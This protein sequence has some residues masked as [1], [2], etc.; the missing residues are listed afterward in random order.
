MN[1]TVTQRSQVLDILSLKFRF[2]Q[3][4]PVTTQI[5]DTATVCR[6]SALQFDKA[7]MSENSLW[8][9]MQGE[10]VKL[11]NTLIRGHEENPNM[12]LEMCK[13]LLDTY[14]GK[15]E[16]ATKTKVREDELR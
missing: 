1:L 5:A 2:F 14:E 10:K 15:A 6:I 3:E 16:E 7:I 4:F 13:T 8:E 9:N 11:L 12:L